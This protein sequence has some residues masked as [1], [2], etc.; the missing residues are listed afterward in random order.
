V[1]YQ[2]QSPG[3]RVP[4][5]ETNMKP[6]HPELYHVQTLQF[7]AVDVLVTAFTWHPK[8]SA[9]AMTLSTSSVCL[10]EV[11]LKD[12]PATKDP[13]AVEFGRHDLEAW[14]VSFLPDGSG[15]YSGGDDSV[16]KYWVPTKT[17]EAFPDGKEFEDVADRMTLQWSDPGRIHGAGVT[18]ILPLDVN[19]EEALILTGS[20][21]E[22][23]SLLN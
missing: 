2:L 15:L 12:P 22:G 6:A 23:K 13:E 7:F 3:S 1:L 9:I 20:Y 5:E 17:A 16:M 18:A 10:E 19:D 11:D 21:D 4:V 14:T 8:R